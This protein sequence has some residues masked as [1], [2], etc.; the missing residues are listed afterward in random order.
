[1]AEADGIGADAQTGT[2]FR[3]DHAASTT[4]RSWKLVPV[5]FPEPRHM[6]PRE[7]RLNDRDG[8]TV[9]HVRRYALPKGSS[10]KANWQMIMIRCQAA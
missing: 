9:Q 1:M 8:A 5:T 6:E 10:P 7:P 3:S 2:V 4:P